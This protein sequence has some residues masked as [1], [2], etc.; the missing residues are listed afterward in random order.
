[1]I[2]TLAAYP[3]A[4]A[5][6]GILLVL[7]PGCVTQAPPPR[8]EPAAWLDSLPPGW[9]EEPV[10]A[11]EDSTTITLRTGSH[12]NTATYRECR[13]LAVLSRNP[14]V[15]EDIVVGHFETFE[16]PP[17]VSV[18]VWYPDGS[19]WRA[20]AADIVSFRYAEGDEYSTN[21]IIEKVTLPRYVKG[22]LIRQEVVRSYFRPEFLSPEAL[23]RG[24]AVRRRT[25]ELSCPADA[26][27]T[28][29]IGNGEGLPLDTARETAEGRSILRLSASMLPKIAP[30][31]R[32]RNPEEWY[33]ALHYSL[34]PAGD[35][36]LS[37][38]DLGEHYRA[39]I[40]P[41][42]EH[43]GQVATLA[44]G[45]D[46]GR[47]EEAVLEAY[48]RVRA[49]I[50]YHADFERLHAI[51]P[52][53]VEEVV[54]KG[55]GDCKEMSALLRAVLDHAGVDVGLA[56][57]GVVG[58]WQALDAIPSLSCFNHVLVYYDRPDGTRLF[59]DPTV[60]FGNPRH[61]SF[62][63]AG[64]RTLLLKERES[65]LDTI[66]L[67][68]GYSNAINTESTVAWDESAESWK[69]RG[70]ASVCGM[71][72]HRLLPLIGRLTPQET[73]P[74]MRTYLQEMLNLRVSSVEVADAES[75]TVRVSFEADFQSNYLDMDAGG[76][77][78][79]VPSLHGG[80]PR[81][82]TLDYE[83][84]RDYV[85]YRQ[86]DVWHLPAGFDELESRELAHAL[87]RGAWE[88]E[89]ETVRRSFTV[90]RARVPVSR[91]EEVTVFG[92]AK[93][94]FSRGRVWRD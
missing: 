32:L 53:P 88:R 3:S 67:A 56:L 84:P 61:S 34:P 75:D 91:R 14:A 48:G 40:A 63:V 83:G 26:R 85:G 13:W 80:D 65:R 68:E 5:A 12:G 46:L 18:T 10:I 50:R 57:V 1:M 37:W 89:G 24:V 69:L 19:M 55:Y 42:F 29:L 92:K 81:F 52:R 31:N 82:T 9:T 44:D 87:G 41:A 25:I 86:E 47:P 71:A 49:A 33:A 78:L 16:H 66:P 51:V 15:F 7:C 27:I 4:L 11:L 38:A 79:S 77:L 76:F 17:S 90:R 74:F 59:L 30:N 58:V 60:R 39:L 6:V 35:T 36:S 45:L 43:R 70:T 62:M 93:F 21:R 8:L 64:Q 73:F 28:T 54:A 23:R 72:A 2:R 94:D 22:M 20:R